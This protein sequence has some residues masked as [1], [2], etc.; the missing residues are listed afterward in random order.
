VH[1]TRQQIY[2]VGGGY[3]YVVL[4]E[5][6]GSHS[7]VNE[8]S[9]LLGCYTISSGKKTQHYKIP[10]TIYQMRHLNIPEN[11]NLHVPMYNF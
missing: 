7:G 11:I 10:V 8:V 4:C 9:S 5:I 2:R 6:W 3:K 1:Q